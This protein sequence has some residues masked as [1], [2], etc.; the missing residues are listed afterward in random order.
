MTRNGQKV[1]KTKTLWTFG[2][3]FHKFDP[4]MRQI[5]YQLDKCN[6][7]VKTDRPYVSI[8]IKHISMNSNCMCI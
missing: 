7:N 2:Q 4:D 1:L 3:F 5:I 8:L 6:K